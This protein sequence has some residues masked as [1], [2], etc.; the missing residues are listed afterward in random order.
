MPGPA[1][2]GTVK[3]FFSFTLIARQFVLGGRT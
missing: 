1:G 3:V 2:A